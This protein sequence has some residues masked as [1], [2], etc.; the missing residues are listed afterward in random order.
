[1]L[2]SARFVNP[3]LRY[4]LPPGSYAWKSEC[5]KSW[6]EF[7]KELW[8]IQL[9][10]VLIMGEV[11]NSKPI[12]QKFRDKIYREINRRTGIVQPVNLAEDE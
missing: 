10:S 11:R 4:L 1:M 9:F 3:V 2:L 12:D 7:A 6:K 8:K 5:W